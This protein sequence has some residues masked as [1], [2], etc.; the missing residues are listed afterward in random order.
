MRTDTIKQSI[1]D[2]LNAHAVRVDAVAVVMP[3]RLIIYRSGPDVWSLP[4]R[5]MRYLRELRPGT[6]EAMAYLGQRQPFAVTS[7]PRSDPRYVGTLRLQKKM[8]QGCNK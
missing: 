8:H 3:L 4:L 6:S 1:A 2:L 7:V 5:P